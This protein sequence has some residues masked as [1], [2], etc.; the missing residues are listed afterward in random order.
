MAKQ[1]QNSITEPS[2]EELVIYRQLVSDITEEQ[3]DELANEY[4]ELVSEGTSMSFPRFLI[5]KFVRPIEPGDTINFQTEE[6]EVKFLFCLVRE[7]IDEVC[8]LLFA[9]ADAESEALNTENV[10]LFNV[11]GKDEINM[12]IIDIMPAGEET[13]R[14]LDLL[15]AKTDVSMAAVESAKADQSEHS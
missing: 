11:C 15:E 6:R 4:F 3:M 13:E 12:E 8:Y 10:Y 7:E 9:E 2:E 5:D 14:I 1:E